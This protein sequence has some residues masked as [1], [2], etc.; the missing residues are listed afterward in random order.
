VKKIIVLLLVSL[1]LIFSF[2]LPA[3]ALTIDATSCILIDAATGRVLYENNAHEA[4]PPASTT[5]T[6][7]ALL[8]LES[9]IAL[10]EKIT[11]PD[12]FVNVGESG[13]NLESGETLTM[14]DLLYALMLRSAN[15]AAQAIAFAVSGSEE[16][17]VE[18]MNVRTAELG[19]TD[20]HWENPH[21][22]DAENHLT[23]A[24]DLAMIAR[25]AITIPFFN[26]LI[27]TD[28]WSLPWAANDSDRVLYNHNQFLTLYEGAD[29]IK[30]GY[31]SLAGNC[32]VAS[33]TRDGM[34]LIGVVMNCPDQTHYAQMTLL[35]DYGFENYEPLTLAKSGDVMGTVKINQ[36]NLSEV[37]AVLTD[38][39]VIAVANGETL[40]ANPK[41]ALP[42]TVDAPCNNDTQIGSVSYQDAEG[43]TV[44]APLYL[45]IDVE[46]YTFSLVIKNVW[47]SVI[48][49]LF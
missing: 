37:E 11:L 49:A 34:R 20:S 8:A 31:T 3:F 15:D 21:G 36:G 12:D 4:L 44:T 6:L 29:G 7:T 35:M 14:E 5:K 25:E 45:K 10:D 41:P 22:L 13:I 27:A 2:S 40:T 1:F 46:R 16:A 33:A 30:T 48:D 42:R 19:L 18:K 38:D 26:E 24:Y 17:F 32:L 39:I 23:S 43:N 28:R 9:G 47:Q